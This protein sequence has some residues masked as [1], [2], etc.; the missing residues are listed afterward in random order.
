MADASI[1]RLLDG[2]AAEAKRRDGWWKRPP[3]GW[4][5]HITLREHEVHDTHVEPETGKEIIFPLRESMET[6]RRGAPRRRHTY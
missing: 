6:Q 3:D 4:P 1:E 2:F 5:N